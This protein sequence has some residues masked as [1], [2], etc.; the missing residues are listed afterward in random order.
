[1][2]QANSIAQFFEILKRYKNYSEIFYRG[3]SSQYE[4]ITSSITRDSGYLANEHII[5]SESIGMKEDEFQLLKSPFERLS[6]LQHY[7]IPTRLIDVTL[8]GL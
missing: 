6:K 3:Q 5:Y 8:E 2:Q 1:M 4:S 7:G